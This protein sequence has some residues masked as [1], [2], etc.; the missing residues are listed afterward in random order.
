MVGRSAPVT[1]PYVDR[2]GVAMTAGGGTQVLAG[3]G[4]LHG[5]GGQSVLADR[6]GAVLVYDHYADDG[7]ALLGIDLLGWDAAGW[8]FIL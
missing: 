7:T 5:P 4:S 6:A 2:A 8:P 1:G 3:H